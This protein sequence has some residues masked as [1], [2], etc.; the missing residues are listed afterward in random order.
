MFSYNESITVQ[1]SRIFCDYYSALM[2]NRYVCFV[3]DFTHYCTVV[4][5]VLL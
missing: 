3:I 2:Y 4:S 1:V 5:Y